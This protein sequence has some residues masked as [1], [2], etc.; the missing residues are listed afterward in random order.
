MSVH[1]GVDCVCVLLKLMVWARLFK[2]GLRKPRVSA[3]F[4][5]RYKRLKGKCL[6]YDLMVE[7]SKEWRKLS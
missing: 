4:E 5:F 3:K 6:V 1:D 2:A 7:C